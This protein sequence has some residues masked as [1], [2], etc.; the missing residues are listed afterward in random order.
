MQGADK[1]TSV[2]L[3]FSIAGGTNPQ[4]SGIARDSFNGCI[5]LKTIEFVLD[6]VS[7]LGTLDNNNNNTTALANIYKMFAASEDNFS[8]NGSNTTPTK[9]NF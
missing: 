2:K 4:N 7:D 8:S 5:E 1:L 3:P 6:N 9:D